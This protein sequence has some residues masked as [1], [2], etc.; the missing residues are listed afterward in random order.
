MTA[1]RMPVEGGP[2]GRWIVLP[3]LT[4]NDRKEIEDG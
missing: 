2:T 1:R 4:T 3:S